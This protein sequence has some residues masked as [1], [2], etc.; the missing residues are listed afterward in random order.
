MKILDTCSIIRLYKEI[1]FPRALQ[2]WRERGYKIVAPPGVFD[3]LRRNTVTIKK[4]QED[5]DNSGLSE[6]DIISDEDRVKF[7]NRHP[8]LGKG[9]IEVILTGKEIQ[10]NNGRYYCVTDDL[11]AEKVAIGY[12]LN[13]TS[14]CNLIKVLY[15][16]GSIESCVFRELASRME[17]FM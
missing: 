8:N 15:S 6:I 17:K 3:E 2:L 4:V 12:G 10:K 9:E 1:L 13:T 14:S 16:K 5:I 7:K 11:I